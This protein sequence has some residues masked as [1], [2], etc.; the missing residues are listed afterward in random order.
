MLKIPDRDIRCRG[1]RQSTHHLPPTQ[2]E[3]LTLTYLHSQRE[4]EMERAVPEQKRDGGEVA[5][6]S[7]GVSHYVQAERLT[8][9]AVAR[10]R[11]SIYQ[12]RI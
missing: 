6:V 5:E 9:Y 8:N 11:W 2:F 4:A 3:P 12:L 10:I 7:L 1:R